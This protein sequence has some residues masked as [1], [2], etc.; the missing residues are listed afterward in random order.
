MRMYDLIAKKK[1]GEELSTE[2]IKFM[3]EGFTKGEIPDYQMSATSFCVSE[4][5]L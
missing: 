2:E 4:N 5:P 1:K 3:I